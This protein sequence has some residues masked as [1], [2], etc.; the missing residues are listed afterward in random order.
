LKLAALTIGQAP[1]IDIMADI[2]GIFS[3][4]IEIIERGALDDLSNEEIKKIYPNK[5]DYILVSR[6]RDGTSAI[7]S[8]KYVERKLQDIIA[9]IEDEVDIFLILCAG[10]FPS[11]NSNKLI[12]KPDILL[13]NS[14]PG[15]IDKGT[16]VDVVPLEGQIEE[17]KTRWTFNNIAVKYKSLCPYTSTKEEIILRAKEIKEMNPDLVLLDCFGFGKDTKK[18]F[19]SVVNKPII[20]VR[21]FVACII[22]ELLE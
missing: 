21:T 20:L 12:I 9:E 13:N 11:L 18:V 16:I 14:I 17:L 19:K 22:K 3:Q 4:N 8:G 5:D 10:T 15:F 6:L 7:I 2:K 1:R